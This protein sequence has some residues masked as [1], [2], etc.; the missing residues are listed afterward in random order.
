[1]ITSDSIKTTATTKLVSELSRL[2]NEIE[3]MIM[4]YNLINNELISRFPFLKEQPEFQ[5][6]VLKKVI[7]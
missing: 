6:K 5:P 7:K 1:M 3:L 2:D 4:K